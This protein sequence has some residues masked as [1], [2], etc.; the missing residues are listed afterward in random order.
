MNL[1]IIVASTRPGR[2]G[3][4]V[5]AWAAERARAHGGFEVEV[6]D[7]AEVDLP[8]F[9]EPRHPR[10]RDYEHEHTKAWSATVDRADAFVIVT[11]EYNFGA[12]PSLVNALDYLVREWAYKPVAF[13]SYGGVSAGLRGVQMTKQIVTALKMMPIPEAVAVPFFTQFVD[14]ETGTFDPGATQATAAAGMLDELARWAGAL[15]PLRAPPSG[16]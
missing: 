13:V 11:P 15:R 5:A 3:A 14:K 7:L 10:L 2:Q 12:P 6:V 4:A 9:D 16:G 1:Q 8:L